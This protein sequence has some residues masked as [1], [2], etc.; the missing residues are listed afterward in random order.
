MPSSLRRRSR[1]EVSWYSPRSRLY[2][3]DVLISTRNLRSHSL[4]RTQVRT[5]TWRV[6]THLLSRPPA[7]GE[8]INGY[9]VKD[10]G[11][12]SETPTRTCNRSSSSGRPGRKAAL[13]R[14]R[15]V[16]HGT[17]GHLLRSILLI[18]RYLIFDEASLCMF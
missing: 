17:A 4:M 13:F 3:P 1:Q 12:T 7:Q 6:P 5:G 9:L 14:N 15:L 10:A 18:A 11:S 16:I 2:C 8:G